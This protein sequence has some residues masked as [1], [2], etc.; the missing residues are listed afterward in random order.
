MIIH[1]LLCFR[2]K[3]EEWN[4][5]TSRNFLTSLEDYSGIFVANVAADVL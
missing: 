3:L 5:F 4:L 1:K 2:Y